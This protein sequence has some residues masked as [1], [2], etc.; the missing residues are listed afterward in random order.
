MPAAA[1]LS[2]SLPA[3][4][5]KCGPEPVST[6]MSSLPARISVQLVGALNSVPVSPDSARSA[7]RSATGASGARNVVGSTRWPSLTMV[8]S[9]LPAMRRC[10]TAANAASAGKAAHAAVP[11]MKSRR[12]KLRVIAPSL[13]RN[14][15]PRGAALCVMPVARIEPPGLAF[16]EPEDYD[17][18]SARIILDH[19]M[20]LHLH[21]IGHVAR[22]RDARELRGHL[23]VDDLDVVGHVALGEAG[24]LQH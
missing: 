13:A 10:G 24:R 21:R 9:K 17:F 11:S 1:R 22:L 4:G 23:R 14:E 7:A 15:P 6:R 16:G 3:L 12:V 2:A 18:N 5:M 19:Q 8:S 20:R